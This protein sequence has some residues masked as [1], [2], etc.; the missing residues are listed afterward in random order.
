MLADDIYIVAIYNKVSGDIQKAFGM[1]SKEEAAEKAIYLRQNA[2]KDIIINK[3]DSNRIE[4]KQL[5]FLYNI[6]LVDVEPFSASDVCVI[7]IRKLGRDD[8]E[9]VCDMIFPIEE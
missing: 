7:G 3:E 1:Y 8:L 4:A 5:D 2:V 9:C 6:N